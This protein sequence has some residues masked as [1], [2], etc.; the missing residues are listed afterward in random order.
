MSNAIMFANLCSAF[1]IK[2]IGAHAIQ[3]NEVST[4]WKDYCKNLSDKM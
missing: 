4:A 1:T 2:K 3:L